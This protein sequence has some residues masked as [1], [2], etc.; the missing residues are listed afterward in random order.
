MP[1]VLTH[2]RHGFFLEMTR[3]IAIA[4]ALGCCA[5][6]PV[7]DRA[8]EFLEAKTKADPDDFIAWNQLGDR[9]LSRLRD[10]GDN[11]WLPRAAA[12]AAA[13]LHALPENENPGGLALHARV[14]IA[15]HRFAAARDCGLRLRELQP[16]KLAAHLILFD[17]HLELG[18]TTAAEATLADIQRLDTNGYNTATRRAR[19][20]N[21]RG[22]RDEARAHFTAAR[23]AASTQPTAI[24]WC[25]I[26][27]GELA[28]RAGDTDAAEKAY[29]AALA[30]VPGGW[31]AREHLAELRASQGKYEDALADITQ[32]IATT[33][34][35][36]LLH[37][38]G[39]L[40]HAAGKTELAADFLN[41]AA[42]AM[43]ASAERGE[44]LYLHHLSSLYA[45]SLKRPADA[46]VWA[47]R[48]LKERQ[49]AASLDA[50]AWALYLAEKLPAAAA[51]ARSALATGTRDPHILYHA[52][53]IL[54]SAGD[55]AAGRAAL[56]AAAEANPRQQAFHFHR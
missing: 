34:R 44:V 10:T 35:P 2:V 20:A 33:P 7:E 4:I 19:L 11:A 22:N 15:S 14:E 53:L 25:E 39:D 42:T 17:A 6:E 52:G 28:F 54:T 41:R 51:N 16:G 40:A 21:A 49:T 27:L 18:D 30:A 1:G 45:D 48:D 37:A 5:A 38:A 26:Q 56:R 29:T 13:S 9:F 50:L 24:A 43:L 36:E 8:L 23:D 3:L 47:E 32:L 31:S 55:L 12:A 46:V